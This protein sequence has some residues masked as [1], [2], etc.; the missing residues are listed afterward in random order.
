MLT[1]DLLE[2]LLLLR[3]ECIIEE[4]CVWFSEW[5]S[6]PDFSC[7]WLISDWLR[8]CKK[9]SVNCHIGL[10]SPGSGMLS[11]YQGFVSTLS[12]LVPEGGMAHNPCY[13]GGIIQTAGLW[14]RL[15][16]LAQLFGNEKRVLS[17]TKKFTCFG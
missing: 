12:A 15:H 6:G 8:S 16:R 13:T 4:L 3:T 1:V 11:L 14:P 7:T 17:V 9:A 10:P 5:L 2:R